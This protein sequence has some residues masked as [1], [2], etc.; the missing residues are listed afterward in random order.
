MKPVCVKCQRFYRVKKNGYRFVEGMP[1]E[2][3]ALPGTQE[4]ERWQPYKLWSSDLWECQGCGHQLLSGFGREPIAEHYQ[5]EF[6]AQ[7]DGVELQVNDC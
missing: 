7:A 1:K 3:G 6:A 4:P 2:D 5:K